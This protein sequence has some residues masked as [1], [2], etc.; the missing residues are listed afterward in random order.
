MKWL[1]THTRPSLKHSQSLRLEHLIPGLILV[2]GYS[3]PQGNGF[4]KHHSNSKQ[5][6]P[7]TETRKQ[8][9]HIPQPLQTVTSDD[10]LVAAPP[11]VNMREYNIDRDRVGH[12]AE[13]T[14]SLIWGWIS[15]KS[16]SKTRTTSA[17]PSYFQDREDEPQGLGSCQVEDAGP[18]LTVAQLGRIPLL[19]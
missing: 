11:W 18:S 12:R 9:L 19:C 4:A 17:S 2:P 7:K 14:K 5:P 8:F 6:V 10:C 15:K 16:A 3:G 1:N 13:H